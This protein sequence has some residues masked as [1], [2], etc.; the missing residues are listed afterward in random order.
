[1]TADPT[2][3]VVVPRVSSLQRRG[4]NLADASAYVGVGKDVFLRAL[5]EGRMPKPRLIG[6]VRVWDVIELDVYFGGLPYDDRPAHERTPAGRRRLQS[7][8]PMGKNG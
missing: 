4:L 3:P 8:A 6:D 5:A 2:P 1:M 7:A